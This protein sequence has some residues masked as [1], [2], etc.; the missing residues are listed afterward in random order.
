MNGNI[1]AF[2][3]YC[4]S[5]PYFCVNNYESQLRQLIDLLLKQ[6][7]TF[8]LLHVFKRND[9]GKDRHLLNPQPEVQLDNQNLFCHFK[10]E[11]L[12]FS[13]VIYQN[14]PVY[15]RRID[16]LHSKLFMMDSSSKNANSNNFYLDK[17][18]LLDGMV[19]YSHWR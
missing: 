18:H 1:S 7:V 19:D 5:I 9:I 13:F 15:I 11:P 12:T 6:F 2:I 8:F 17:V 3:I 10:L 14:Y 16:N 4:L